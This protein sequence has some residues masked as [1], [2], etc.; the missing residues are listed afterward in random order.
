VVAAFFDMD[1]TLVRVNTG[2]LW[3]KYL[4]RR[5]E[6]SRLEMIRALTWL[7]QYKFS[8]LDFAS[9]TER[10]AANMAGDSENELAEK[11]RTWVGAEVVPEVVPSARERIAHHRAEGHVCVILSSSSRYVTEPLAAELALDGVLCTRLEVA[12]GRFT[13]RVTP[14]VCYGA[15]KVEWAERFAAERGVDLDASWFYTDSYSDLPMLERVGQKV[16]VNPD[17]RLRRFA[18]RAG[19]TVEAW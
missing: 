4:R 7:L 12:D 10:V 9:V 14:P 3:V 13:G 18:R 16:V 19:W 2:A 15:G 8:V 1:R 17:P 6:M 5:R 11:C